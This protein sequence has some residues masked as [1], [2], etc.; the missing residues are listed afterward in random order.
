MLQ[1]AAKVQQRCQARRFQSG[2]HTSFDDHMVVPHSSAAQQQRVTL[3]WCQVWCV[4]RK[5]RQRIRLLCCAVGVHGCVTAGDDEQQPTVHASQVWLPGCSPVLL[6]SVCSDSGRP[7]QHCL[8]CY[9][10]CKGSCIITP[11]ALVKRGRALFSRLRG[12]PSLHNTAAEHVSPCWSEQA[13]AH[14]V[15]TACP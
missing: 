5:H 7:A 10:P 11:R 2:P 6:P 14:S 1:A 15:L 3:C 9:M 12:R 4:C 8:D 13:G